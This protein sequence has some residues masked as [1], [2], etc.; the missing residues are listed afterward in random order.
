MA[1]VTTYYV[2]IARRNFGVVARAG[3]VADESVVRVQAVLT[4]VGCSG[5]T[6]SPAGCPATQSLAAVR[7]RSANYRLE[8][9]PFTIGD[10]LLLRVRANAAT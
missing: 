1:R 8:G 2:R 4:I 10:G 9:A 7:V 5:T 3:V 6:G